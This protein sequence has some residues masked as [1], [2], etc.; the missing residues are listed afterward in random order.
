MSKKK[1][2]SQSK[3]K[4]WGLASVLIAI[5]VGMVLVIFIPRLSAEEIT[6]HD[7]HGIGYSGDSLTVASH[8]GLTKF[9]E[10]KWTVPDGEKHDYMGYSAVK[11]GF[12]SSGHPSRTSKL[13]NPLGV[14]K[15]NASGKK[16]T[17]LDLEGE[18]DF[19]TMT[20]GYETKEVYVINLEKNTRMEEPGLYYTI[21]DTKTWTKT[22][23][24]GVTDPPTTI[25]AH[26]TEKGVVAFGTEHGLY[27]SRD[28]GDTFTVIMPEVPVSALAF[29]HGG[30]LLVGS[31]E[32]EPEVFQ[33][34]ISTKKTK[35]LKVPVSKNDMVMYVQQNPK[36]Q[37]EYALTTFNKNIYLTEDGGGKWD[38]IV[39]EGQTK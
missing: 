32:N 29:D 34:D 5:L 6:F 37:D 12:Y 30:N 16:I 21:D 22:N 10:G 23:M 24:A 18:M 25:A 38:K 35:D 11:D 17:G 7:I 33:L 19:H 3:K 26:P 14:V 20:A 28:Y 39:D 8:T 1:K 15:G 27:L 2:M 13:A 9:S 4:S 31:L 36:D